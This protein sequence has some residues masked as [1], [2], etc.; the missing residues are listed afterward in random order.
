MDNSGSHTISPR[1]PVSNPSNS[2]NKGVRRNSSSLQPSSEE[3]DKPVIPGRR[4]LKRRANVIESDSDDSDSDDSDDEYVEC[5]V[6]GWLFRFVQYGLPMQRLML[7][8]AS[9]SQDRDLYV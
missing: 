7:F 9:Q 3:Q 4:R 1:S 2:S 8:F 6:S 5:H